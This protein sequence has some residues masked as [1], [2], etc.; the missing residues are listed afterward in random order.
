MT[1][2]L[3]IHII[4]TKCF[5]LFTFYNVLDKFCLKKTKSMI[6]LV[7]RKSQIVP[8]KSQ[9]VPRKSRIVPRKS[10]F[11]ENHKTCSPKITKS[12]PRKSQ[13]VF[14]ENHVPRK[15]RTS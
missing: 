6:F 13:K 3:V 12:V 1:R 9:I 5:V 14:L 2:V 4:D 8:R 7:P 10:L 11:P 15:S